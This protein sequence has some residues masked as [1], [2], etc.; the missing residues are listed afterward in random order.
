MASLQPEPASCSHT[1]VL[2]LVLEE[3]ARRRP[4]RRKKEQGVQGVCSR[5]VRDRHMRFEGVVGIGRMGGMRREGRCSL[6]IGEVPQVGAGY[7][8]S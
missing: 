4:D 1:P 7:A 3:V 8:I 5:R 6:E 2:G